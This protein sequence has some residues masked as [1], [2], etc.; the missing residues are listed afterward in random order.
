MRSREATLSASLLTPDTGDAYVAVAQLDEVQ[1]TVT[2]SVVKV[3]G[4]TATTLASNVYTAQGQNAGRDFLADIAVSPDGNRIYLTNPA[5]GSVSVID[6]ATGDVLPGIQA[7]DVQT[8]SAP[9]RVLFSPDGSEAYVVD[10][11]GGVHVVT[12]AADPQD[13]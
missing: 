7:T 1:Q 9:Q 10:Q 13:L 4:G 3:S 8:E 5:D 12:F 6:A 11:L 2:M